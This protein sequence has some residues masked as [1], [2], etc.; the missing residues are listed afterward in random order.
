MKNF[1]VLLFVSAA[2]QQAAVLDG[3]ITASSNVDRSRLSVN[4]AGPRARAQPDACRRQ[5]RRRVPYCGF[6]PGH[7]YAYGCGSVWDSNRI[8]TRAR[9]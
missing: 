8:P 1:I 9:Q 4:F 2:A 3:E 6:E 7:L 5:L